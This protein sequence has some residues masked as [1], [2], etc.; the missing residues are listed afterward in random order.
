MA[1]NV[2]QPAH[3]KAGGIE[4]IDYIAANFGAEAFRDYCVGNVLKYASRWRHKNGIED[5]RKASVYLLW[6]INGNPNVKLSAPVPNDPFVGGTLL[7]P[8]EDLAGM[9][10]AQMQFEAALNANPLNT[11]DT[12]GPGEV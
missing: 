9:H 7:D 5:L 10:R 12:V 6:A 2:N 4:T 8:P 3:Y 1:D 11:A